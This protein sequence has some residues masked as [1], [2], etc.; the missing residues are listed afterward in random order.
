M[1]L[2]IFQKLVL[3]TKR[4][5]EPCISVRVIACVRFDITPSG[6]ESEIA[7]LYGLWIAI[8]VATADSFACIRIVTPRVAIL[9]AFLSCPEAYSRTAAKTHSRDAGWR[10]LAHSCSAS[11]SHSRSAGWRI[12][13]PFPR[14]PEPPTDIWGVGLARGLDPAPLAHA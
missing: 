7:V 8:A 6:W 13:H 9:R 2:D 4:Q 3:A 14:R 10:G 12:L 11:E 5:S 1:G